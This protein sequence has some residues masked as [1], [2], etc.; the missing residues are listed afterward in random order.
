VSRC[1]S[2]ILETAKVK[3]ARLV[4]TICTHR[5]TKYIARENGMRSPMKYNTKAILRHL[6]VP[7]LVLDRVPK[8][9]HVELF[10][11]NCEENQRFDSCSLE[12]RYK[13]ELLPLSSHLDTAA[14]VEELVELAFRYFRRTDIR[15]EL[16]HLSERKGKAFVLR[17]VTSQEIV[18]SCVFDTYQ[19]IDGDQIVAE[20]FLLAVRPTYRG[21]GAS[22]LLLSEVIGLGRKENWRSVFLVARNR[23]QHIYRSQGFREA[24]D[25]DLAFIESL[26]GAGIV[27]SIEKNRLLV[28][29][30]KS[31]MD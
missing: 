28:L 23:V 15:R 25:T 7:E 6:K 21:L 24:N 4:F 16:S 29:H 22:R 2:R 8:D 5:A 30:L 3:G 10:D 11:Y 14:K 20:V 12:P 19:N 1:E 13:V 9:H 17:E 27:S 18:A 26:A 31:S